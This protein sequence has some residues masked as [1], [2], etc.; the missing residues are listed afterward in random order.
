MLIPLGFFDPGIAE[1]PFEL[2]ST[3]ILASATGTVTFASIPQTYKHL[4]LRASSRSTS[5]SY[6]IDSI[7]ILFNGTAS[8]YARHQMYTTG[9]SVQYAYDSTSTYWIGGDMTGNASAAQVFA[10]TIIDILDYTN[11]SKYKVSRSMTG[12]QNTSSSTSNG[13]FVSGLWQS[14]AAITQ[15]S[16]SSFSTIDSLSR[17]SLYGIRG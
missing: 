5:P 2:I 6:S 4:Q 14:T 3:Q 13:G 15:I 7:K 12:S 17:F 8:G 1:P 11:T 10:P 9:G 16:I